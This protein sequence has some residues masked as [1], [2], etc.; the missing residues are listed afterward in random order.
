MITSQNSNDD[1]VYLP[2]QDCIEYFDVSELEIVNGSVKITLE[3]IYQM[4]SETFRNKILS[5]IQ[6]FEQSLTEH[7]SLYTCLSAELRKLDNQFLYISRD[8]FDLQA[9]RS[10]PP[11]MYRIYTNL[12]KT[13]Y[14]TFKGRFELTLFLKS[15]GLNYFDQFQLWKKYLFKPGEEWHFE[16]QIN[17]FL[18]QLYGLTEAENHFYF[19]HKCT[20]MIN[21]D[22]PA[23]AKMV[24]GCPFKCLSRI[25][26]KVFLKKMRRDIKHSEIDKLAVDAEQFPIQACA[27][28]F[29]G[30]AEQDQKEFEKPLQYYLES[31]K[32]INK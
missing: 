22:S 9:E 1:I 6:H 16:S 29:A 2:F 25:D 23:A 18:R 20:T 11:C 24:Q 32:R 5:N 10:F 26:L 27:K 19:P 28:F 17:L 30:N 31:E 8:T 13:H 4:V 7:K 3:H 14:A 15:L 12:K 21:H